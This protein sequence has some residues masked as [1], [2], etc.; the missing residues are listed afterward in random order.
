MRLVKKIANIEYEFIP[1]R[2]VHKMKEIV[3]YINN[4]E[5]FKKCMRECP[6]IGNLRKLME[7]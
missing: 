4:I 5:K 7:E 2:D 1:A 3:I 6:A